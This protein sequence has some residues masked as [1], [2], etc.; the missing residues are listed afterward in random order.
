MF[1]DWKH[2]ELEP[3]LNE[4]PYTAADSAG[5]AFM[6]NINQRIVED[7][8]QKFPEIKRD[9]TPK[10]N[11]AFNYFDKKIPFLRFLIRAGII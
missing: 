10:Y 9:L 2:V 11:K 4:I 1:F 3:E 5:R 7:I 6:E 8:L